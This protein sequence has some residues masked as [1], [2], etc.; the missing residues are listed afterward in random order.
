[1]ID[2]KNTCRDYAQSICQNNF[3]KSRAREV[4]PQSK[5]ISQWLF[6]ITSH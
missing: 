2:T 4:I 6:R 1:M 5:W 3:S